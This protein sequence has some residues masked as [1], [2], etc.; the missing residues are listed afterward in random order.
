MTD[1]Y[2]DEYYD[3]AEHSA[4]ADTGTC[5]RCEEV[6]VLVEHKIAGRVCPSC[7]EDALRDDAEYAAEDR[8]VRHAEN[9]YGYSGGWSGYEPYSLRD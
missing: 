9:G 1:Y 2:D 5:E 6:D 3:A 8:A 7:L 4:S